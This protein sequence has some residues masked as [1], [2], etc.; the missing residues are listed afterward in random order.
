LNIGTRTTGGL[1]LKCRVTFFLSFK[2]D[3]GRGIGEPLWLLGC[4]CICGL[5]LAN[6]GVLVSVKNRLP[7]NLL[8]CLHLVILAVALTPVVLAAEPLN[9]S[10]NLV[11]NEVRVPPTGE[12]LVAEVLAATKNSRPW[13]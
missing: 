1:D 3:L 10:L 8:C 13:I 9:F 6:L 12:T 4:L 11:L 7:V 2:K 5:H